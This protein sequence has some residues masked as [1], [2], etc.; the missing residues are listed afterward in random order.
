[1]FFY[2][3]ESSWRVS[4]KASDECLGRDEKYVCKA[5]HCNILTLFA[6]CLVN[7]KHLVCVSLWLCWPN[8][9]TFFTFTSSIPRTAQLPTDDIFSAHFL[10][11]GQ[12][13]Q[14]HSFLCFLATFMYV[15]F[16]MHVSFYHWQRYLVQKTRQTLFHIFRY[17]RSFQFQQLRTLCI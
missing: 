5:S 2:L 3:A 14:H 10:K 9:S 1:M 13:G 4:W 17:T 8:G 11:Q 7:K 15:G 16:F 6:V 12:F